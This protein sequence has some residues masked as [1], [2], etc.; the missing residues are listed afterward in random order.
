MKFWELIAVFREEANLLRRV[1]KQDKWARYY[2]LYERL[3]EITQKQEREVLD[4]ELPFDL[5]YEVTDKSRQEYWLS[6]N[7]H[8]QVLY[9][10]RPDIKELERLRPSEI[11]VRFGGSKIQE[12][13]AYGS[14]S[15]QPRPLKGNIEVMDS[16]HLTSLGLLSIL[17]AE[18]HLVDNCIISTHDETK[19][20]KLIREFKPL[21]ADPYSAYEKMEA[22]KKQNI[23]QYLLTGIKHNEKP[24]PGELLKIVEK[25]P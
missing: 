24:K 23:K 22:Q 12:A 7:E 2:H 9:N 1:L 17:R 8:P 5:C 6:F 20:W 14:T 21:F 13:R 18:D 11:L 25:S 16:C 4:E 19:Q 3:D 15:V 10:Y